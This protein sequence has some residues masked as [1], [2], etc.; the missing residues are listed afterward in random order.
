MDVEEALGRIEKWIMEVRVECEASRDEDVWMEEAW[1][2]VKG[3]KLRAEDVRKARR[4]EVEYMISRRIWRLVPIGDCWRKTGKP[5][6]GTRWVDTNKGTADNPDV[7]SRLVARDFKVKADKEREDLFAATPPVEAERMALS[8]AVT[9]SRHADGSRKVRKIMFVDAKKAHLNPVCQ[10]DVFIELPVEAGAGE[11]VCG[12]LVHW[13]YGCRPAAQAWEKFY[14]AK[15]EGVGFARGDAC[16]VV[17]YHEA[18]DLCCVCHGDDFT[19]VGEDADLQWIAAEMKQWFEI[20]VRAILG[21]EDKDDKEVV[22]LGRLVRWKAW[23][24]EFEADPRHRDVLKEYFGFTDGSCSA[25][26]NGD[27]LKEEPEDDH[28]MDAGEAREFRGL[29]A[30]LNYLA[31]D[32]PDLQYPAKE[33]SKHMARPHRGAW[34]QLKKTVR[35]LL[36]RSAVVWRYMWQDE[37]TFMTVKT[38]SDWGGSRGDRRSTSGGTIMLGDH[39]L[40][41]WSSTQGAIALSSAEAEFYA[42]VDGVL[43]AKWLTTVS[44]EM[45]FRTV[46]GRI[47]LGTDSAAAK[48]FVSRRG[49]GKMR[50]IE[51]RDLWL[52]KE[53]LKGAVEVIKIPGDDNPADLMTKFLSAE[54][55]EKRLN[56]MGLM[57]VCGNDVKGHKKHDRQEKLS[58]VDGEWADVESEGDTGLMETVAWWSR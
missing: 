25:A 46:C 45:G 30:R 5:P 36:G 28:E 23:G 7:R 57:K 35:Y 42:M 53:V 56:S 18:R 32:S 29:V 27:H 11:G 37:A 52:Q 22:I 20:K 34:R 26:C 43:K 12:Q 33:I 3:G 40:K 58:L 8:R 6:V 9:R 38:D 48:S 55:V 2:D 14:A 39:C 49:L 17:F 13:L 15:L 10:D 54:V 50:H 19:L 4:E 41:T 24:V 51:V 31:Q 47:V 44:R 21:P 16:G 1:D